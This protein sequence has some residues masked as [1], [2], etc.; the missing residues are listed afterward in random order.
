[1]PRADSAARLVRAAL[2]VVPATVSGPSAAPATDRAGRLTG[3]R[4]G[5]VSTRLGSCL[6]ARAR[7]ALAADKVTITIKACLSPMHRNRLLILALGPCGA[8][9]LAPH[10]IA[11]RIA[12][13]EARPSAS[14]ITT[15]PRVG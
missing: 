7:V 3:K 6:P 13:L 9:R 8:G 4:R 1:M 2:H 15:T 11:D 12:R 14:T 5:P 10:M